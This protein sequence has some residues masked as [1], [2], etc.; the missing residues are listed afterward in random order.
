MECDLPRPDKHSL[1]QEEKQPAE[2]QESMRRDEWRERSE[3]PGGIDDRWRKP[4]EGDDDP[5]SSTGWRCLRTLPLALAPLRL[6]SVV[7]P[8]CV[9]R[10][11]LSMGF[12]PGGNAV[13]PLD[14]KDSTRTRAFII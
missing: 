5:S 13:N 4:R 14:P 11:M 10:L 8:G 3:A 6:R 12:L 2:H 9:S 1:K 7:G